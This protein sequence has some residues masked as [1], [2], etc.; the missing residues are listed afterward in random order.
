M[1]APPL[2]LP[3]D[4]PWVIVHI[5]AGVIAILAGYA[6][7]SL[8]KGERLH[9]VF[10]TVFILAM[11]TASALA[12][13]LAAF[14]PPAAPGGAPPSGSI[15]VGFLTIYLVVTAWMTVRRKERG[16]GSLDYAALIAAL[17]AAGALALFG[18][19]AASLHETLVAPYYIFAGF[20][21]FAAALDLKVILQGGISGA[22][23]IA[24][25]LWRM[26]F[27]F[28]FASAFFFLGQQKV[29]PQWM[30]GAWYLYVLGLAPLAFLVFWLLRVR[31]TG[32]FKRNPIFAPLPLADAPRRWP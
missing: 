25:H 13:Y 6:A 12:V 10:G 9:R 7:I 27:A 29:M 3:A 22:A 26:C 17:G 31:F 28:F 11:L 8:R 32:W 16:V 20:A 14:V 19:R 15:S 4:M 30:H 23:R 1:I 24:R 21:A 5:S 18:L 2:P